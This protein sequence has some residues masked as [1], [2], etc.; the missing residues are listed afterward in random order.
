MPTEKFQKL[1]EVA[2]DSITSNVGI[3]NT[4]K[5]IGNRTAKKCT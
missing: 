3:G 4:D 1:K 2:I 5:Q